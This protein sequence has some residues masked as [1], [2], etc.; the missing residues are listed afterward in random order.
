MI[1]L[2]AIASP[3]NLKD[4]KRVKLTKDISKNLGPCKF[5]KILHSEKFLLVKSW[6]QLWESEIPPGA[7]PGARYIK[8][9]NT[10]FR[11]HHKEHN[12]DLWP[13]H[14][15]IINFT[16]YNWNDTIV[17]ILTWYI[18]HHPKSQSDLI[19]CTWNPESTAWDPDYARLPNWF[20]LPYIEQKWLVDSVSVA[21]CSD[22]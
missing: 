5:I 6:I 9:V 21:K 14:N 17:D 22:L 3:S 10:K 1:S 7:T 15:N 8:T 12:N 11:S 19:S 18:E 4:C 13:L 16:Q 2:L 20:G